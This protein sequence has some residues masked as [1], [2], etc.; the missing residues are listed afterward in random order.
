ME[1]SRNLACS[2]P[3]LSGIALL[4]VWFGSI[5]G[6]CMQMGAKSRMRGQVEELVKMVMAVVGGLDVD[7]R[8]L[9]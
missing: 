4:K 7:P 6:T 8:E 5:D 3:K 1:F 2:S 9:L